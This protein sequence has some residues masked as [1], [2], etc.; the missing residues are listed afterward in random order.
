MK[1]LELTG[2][3]RPATTERGRTF[4]DKVVSYSRLLPLLMNFVQKPTEHQSRLASGTQSLAG[5]QIGTN[6]A[7]E[8]LTPAALVAGL[9]SS[10]SFFLKYDITYMD[11]ASQGIGI[12]MDQWYA[13]E[14][15][16]RAFSAAQAIDAL[17]IAGSGAGNN[18]LGIAGILDGVTNIPG[19]GITG[20][21]DALAGAGLAGDSFDLSSEANYP[22][23]MER[24]NIWTAE[25]FSS[26]AI[27][28]NH[29]MHG[30]LTN[31]AL[32]RHMYTTRMD[33]FG[34]KVDQIAGHDII[35]VDDSVITN[36]EDDNGAGND[37]TSIY[38]FTNKEGF[39]NINSNSGLAFYDHGELSGELQD[40]IL[41]DFRAKNEIKRKRAIR[42]I[43]NI[44]V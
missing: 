33:E 35:P 3:A 26:D 43:R 12:E 44:K 25:L 6:P 10:H 38:I 8:Q 27:I 14:L 1:I 21:I 40:G 39:W 13:D 16:E 34:N 32:N 4:I 15:D 19:L 23:F 9:L 24:F 30:R 17:I 22:K 31:V 37:T 28:C 41:F 7:A 5:R 18:M 2:R 42:R 29:S 36:G 20:V 11:D